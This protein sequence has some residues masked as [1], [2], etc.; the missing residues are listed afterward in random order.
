MAMQ[1]ATIGTLLAVAVMSVIMSAFGALVATQRI[2]NSGS[3]SAI[4]VGVYSDSN[5]MTPLSSISWG[6]LD[7]GGSVNYTMY[8]KNTGNIPVTLTMAPS[9]WNPTT[10]SNYITLTWNQQN[11]VLSPNSV[12]QAVLTLSVSS[13]ISSITNFS[14]DITITGTEHA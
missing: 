9:N 6:T 11:T 4:G 2:T 8:V 7:P 3:I 12:V 10:A 5:C 14:C 13:S 1:K